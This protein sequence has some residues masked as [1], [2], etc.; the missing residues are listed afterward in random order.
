MKWTVWLD[1]DDPID[2]GDWENRDSFP[3]NVVCQTPTA[4]QAQVKS[5]STGSTEVVHR[6]TEH[7]GVSMMSSQKIKSLPTSR[8]VSVARLITTIHVSNTT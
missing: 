2:S 5:G 8:C 6:S 1:S 7:S 3:A 4:M